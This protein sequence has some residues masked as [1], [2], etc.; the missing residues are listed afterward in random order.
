MTRRDLV[1][2]ASLVLVL[3]ALSWPTAADAR[4]LVR[5]ELETP[6]AGI[7]V[8]R[9]HDDGRPLERPCVV[10][11]RHDRRLARSLGRRYDI[12]PAVLLDLRRSGH[13]WPE[14]RAILRLPH[15]LMQ[16]A[17]RPERHSH[18]WCGTVDHRGPHHRQDRDDHRRGDDHRH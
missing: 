10:I 12:Y 11:D 13:T 7:V 5:V 17:L 18:G 9:L 3:I 1:G 2:S 14:I 6:H 15:H 8:S 4:V 16:E